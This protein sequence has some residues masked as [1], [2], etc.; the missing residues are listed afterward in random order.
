MHAI[1]SSSAGTESAA[2]WSALTQ[3][4]L[5]I[6]VHI[7]LYFDI[8]FLKLSGFLKISKPNTEHN[9]VCGQH[10]PALSQV[11]FVHVC[12]NDW[13]AYYSNNGK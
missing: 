10:D 4:I 2:W 6:T 12:V 9:R 13:Q 1:V 3:A 11:I 7:D 5:D 8:S